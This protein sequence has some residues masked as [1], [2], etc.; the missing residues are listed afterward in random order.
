MAKKRKNQIEEVAIYFEQKRGWA[1]IHEVNFCL[2]CIHILYNPGPI[3][4]NQKMAFLGV[5]ND[6]L[7]GFQI[8]FML[9]P[10]KT[11]VLKHII[12][13]IYNLEKAQN[14]GFD[15]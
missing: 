10:L 13:A 12:L 9:A 7:G 15:S 2:F 6:F 4:V 5:W 3:K 11:W 8:Q 14:S 1:D